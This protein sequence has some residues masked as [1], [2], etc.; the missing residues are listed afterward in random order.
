MNGSIL[1]IT[2]NS[3]H[4]TKLA[5]KSALAQDVPCDVFVID[6]CSLDGTR[7]WLKTKPVAVAH[8]SVQKSLAFC[9]NRGLQTFWKIGARQVLVINNDVVLRPDTYRML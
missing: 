9:W 8:Y 1:I 6:N 3:L 5:V 7:D 4:L 2:R